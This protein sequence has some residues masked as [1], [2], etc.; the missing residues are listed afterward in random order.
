MWTCKQVSVF[1]NSPM[2]ALFGMEPQCWERCCWSCCM[3]TCKRVCVF[4][5]ASMRKLL[6]WSR[7]A[8]RVLLE[9][10]HVLAGVLA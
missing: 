7:I 1:F 3:W 10:L 8:G 6:G 2:W 9:L 5:N 4:S